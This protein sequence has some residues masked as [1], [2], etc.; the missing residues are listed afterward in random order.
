MT[1]VDLSKVEKQ[2][3]NPKKVPSKVV[4][5]L[6]VWAEKVEEYG[7]FQVKAIKHYRDHA[8]KGQRK[9][10]RSV[11]LSYQWRAIYTQ[12][13]NGEIEIVTV[14]EITAHDYRTK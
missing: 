2:L 7:L 5:A 3:K 11:T 12:K 4:D 9:G 10:Q 6:F 1:E 8:L 14:E 13:K